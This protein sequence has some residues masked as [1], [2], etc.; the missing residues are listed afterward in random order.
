MKECAITR[1]LHFRLVTWGC[2]SVWWTRRLRLHRSCCTPPR[3]TTDPS[4]R[5]HPP[6]ESHTP[7]TPACS[8]TAAQTKHI[9]IH[10]FRYIWQQ[11]CTFQVCKANCLEKNT[12]SSYPP[13]PT[14]VVFTH[15]WCFSFKKV[16]PINIFIGNHLIQTKQQPRWVSR[17]TCA[18]FISL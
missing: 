15:C 2:H 5:P 16:N 11:G 17:S 3:G 1:E 14:T 4:P 12:D 18:A 10:M 9:F 8:T 7:H 6:D 13:T